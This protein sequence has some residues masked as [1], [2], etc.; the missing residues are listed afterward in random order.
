M[1]KNIVIDCGTGA[2]TTSV[3]KLMAKLADNRVAAVTCCGGGAN[4]V[5]EGIVSAGMNCSVFHGAD[6]PL[7][8]QKPLTPWPVKESAVAYG[9]GY[10]WDELYRLAEDNSKPL[11]IL[12]LGPLTN[13]AVALM[14]YENLPE[15]LERVVMVAGS[16]GIG[17]LTAFGEANVL[18][19]PHACQMVLTSG[20]PVLM[21]GLDAV[22]GMEISPALQ[23]KLDA[24]CEAPVTPAAAAAVSALLWPD[25]VQHT[26]Y[27]VNVE[28]VHGP[29]FGR[30]L[31]DIRL[32][33]EAPK[34]TMVAQKILLNQ[35]DKHL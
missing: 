27:S 34:T 14:K 21:V 1:N 22:Q 12:A 20:I 15:K 3:L 32:H 23:Q 17:D 10:A 9:D 31:V 18:A 11:T 35:L 25:A 16:A 29:M 30:T 13:L 2:T 8:E 4:T 33:S 26:L 28:L 7:I 6:K 5:P 24:V 19:D